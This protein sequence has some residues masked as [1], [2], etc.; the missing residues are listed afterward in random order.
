[1][2]TFLI[3]INEEIFTISDEL[4]NLEGK[5]LTSKLRE[6]EKRKNALTKRIHKLLDSEQV[7]HLRRETKEA[8]VK[9]PRGRSG[10]RKLSENKVAVKPPIA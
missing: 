3:E 4:A 8:G 2:D 6:F 1:V 9:S 7:M 5:E 10:P